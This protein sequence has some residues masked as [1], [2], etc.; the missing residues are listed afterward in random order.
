M[1]GVSGLRNDAQICSNVNLNIE[2]RFKLNNPAAKFGIKM[3][4]ARNIRFEGDDSRFELSGTIAAVYVQ[5]GYQDGRDINVAEGLFIAAPDNGGNLVGFYDWKGTES[6]ETGEYC[7]FIAG[8][9]GNAAKTVLIKPGKASPYYLGGSRI[10]SDNMNNIPVAE[11]KASYDFDTNTL[12]LNKVK[13]NTTE[14]DAQIL[15][16]FEYF[17]EY[18][19]VKDLDRGNFKPLTVRGSAD[20]SVPGS[21]H[22]FKEMDNIDAR[23]AGLSNPNEIYDEEEVWSHPYGGIILDGDF[24]LGTAAGD[25]A[26]YTQGPV[27][28]KKRSHVTVLGTGITSAGLTIE[29]GCADLP[30]IYSSHNNV[31]I[32]GGI[33]NI[34]GES[35]YSNAISCEDL[36]LN[37][38]IVSVVKKPSSSS[39]Y[40]YAIAADDIKINGGDLYAQGGEDGSSA[41][42]CKEYGIVSGY[43]IAE[44][45][46]GELFKSGSTTY[47]YTDSSHSNKSRTLRIRP[48]TYKTISFDLNGG[49]GISLPA[50]QHIGIGK[51]AYEP[52]TRELYNAGSVF[53]GWCIGS[54]GVNPFDFDKPVTDLSP[55]TLYAG[56]ELEGSKEWTVSFDLNGHD[57]TAPET[58][59]VKHGEKA[60]DPGFSEDGFLG[61]F[62]TDDAAPAN[63]FDFNSPVT[64]D[65]TLYAGWPSSEK[66]S[67]KFEL[68]GHGGTA[69]S[70]QLI[71]KG[72]KAVKPED[73]TAAGYSFG[74]WFKDPACTVLFDFNS[75][76]NSNIVLYAKWVL[77]SSAVHVTF[78]LNG[79]TGTVP[80]IQTVE[81]GTKA[82]RPADPVATGFT[83][84]GW[85]RDPACTEAFSFDTPVEADMTLY[86]KWTEKGP[87]DPGE[88]GSPSINRVPITDPDHQSY[89]SDND[90][91]AP[92]ATNGKITKLV[93]DFSQVKGSTVSAADLR[94]T[95]IKGSKFTTREKLRDRKS[96]KADPGIKVKVNKKTL[97]PKITVK[98]SGY[99]ELECEGDV[100]YKIYF[101]VETPK[102]RKD[103]KKIIKGSGTVQK[104][105]LDLFGTT[106]T[107]GKLSLKKNKRSQASLSVNSVVI[108]PVE[109][110]SIKIQYEYLKKKYKI[111]V[112]IK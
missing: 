101:T 97:I 5:D 37:D 16:T 29:G 103:A 17:H 61:W 20:L 57:G 71:V 78:D 55:L 45:L 99:L 92:V 104:T 70:N 62:L 59:S 35:E 66:V 93:L 107:A 95:V 83:F 112:K 21:K 46:G 18:N 54:G 77:T 14:N 49:G 19:Q 60:S 87:D 110:D 80:D 65:L 106:I 40:P 64:G 98:K 47:V 34:K 102:A 26:I 100:T 1:T 75:P 22:G 82:V 33:V 108:N 28:I 105:I 4:N 7:A 52:D 15:H 81:K 53:K 109:K 56:W 88:G 36:I 76:V 44:P 89:P 13:I 85:Y 67:V 2:G 91:I 38:G 58:Q 74:G 27:T 11:G 63:E 48:T 94:M 86:A 39:P 6:P 41:I 69:P 24:T 9:D 96:F 43:G 10:T 8:S 68:N 3:M 51:K 23:G 90:N 72:N 31:L 25:A 111:T 84:A 50:E 12:T 73:P 30:R 32:N 79:K 42:S